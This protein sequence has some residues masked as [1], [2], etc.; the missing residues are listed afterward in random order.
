[1]VRMGGWLQHQEAGETA[2]CQQNDALKGEAV[3]AAHRPNGLT[4]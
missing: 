1:M 3:A 4:Q 2:V